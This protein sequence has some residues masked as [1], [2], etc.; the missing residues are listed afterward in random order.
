MTLVHKLHIS[1][2]CLLSERHFS[3]LLF[4][5]MD[6]IFLLMESK[7]QMLLGATFLPK[8]FRYVPNSLVILYFAM[9]HISIIMYH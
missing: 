2:M 1:C 4:R 6:I 9:V 3:V 5:A 7:Y 8:V